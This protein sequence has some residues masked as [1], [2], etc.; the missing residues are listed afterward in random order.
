MNI[1]FH[2]DIHSENSHLC[3]QQLTHMDSTAP[4][5]LKT[6]FVTGDFPGGPVGKT[7]CSQCRGP[8]FDP[9]SGN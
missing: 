1:V 2:T 9:W 5:H 8:G 3:S 4:V 7:P 6:K